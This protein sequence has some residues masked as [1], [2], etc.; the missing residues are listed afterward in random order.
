MGPQLQTDT[1]SQVRDDIELPGYDREAIK[2]GIVHFGP[3][4]FHRAHQAVFTDD[5][6]TKSG[7]DWGICG[8]SLNSRGTAE[9]MTAQHGLYTLAIKDKTPRY[10]VIGAMKEALC[11]RDDPAR[12]LERLSAASTKFVTMTITE[13][14]YALTA[15][16]HLDKMNP[17]IQQDLLNPE[18][19]VSAI[20]YLVLAI[21]DRKNKDLLPLT[22]ISCDNL[23]D[24]GHK[25]A[26]VC[27][28]YAQDLD[29]E[30]AD[31][32]KANVRFPNTMVDSI[33]PATDEA[34]KNTVAE[35]TGLIDA[36]P[37]Q[38]EA[39]KQWVIEDN[40]PEDRPD[41]AGAGA[42]ITSDVAGFEKTKLR[43]LNGAHSTLT[44]LG[45]LAGLESVE[46]A[47]N[48]PH[49]R[50]F[51]DTM[52]VHETIPTIE[53]PK[54]LS[55]KH[56]W[57]QIIARFEN[58]HIRHLLEQISHDG[59]QKIPARI[60]PVI[61]AHIRQGHLAK[62]ACFVLSAWIVFNQTRRARNNPPTDGFLNTI[63][64][65]LPVCD[66]SAA[67]Y[68]AAFLALD[69]VIAPELSNNPDVKACVIQFC[70]TIS[71]LGVIAALSQL[72]IQAT[73]L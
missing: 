53:A 30:L 22:I 62:R 12:V 31:Y 69:T 24:N 18:T 68:A 66:L 4:A 46:D 9:A 25:L 16:G 45:L 47:I 28:E 10:R 44:Y 37:V 41:W 73:N 57:S 32:I 71:E 40:L 65:S 33:T 52:I 1:L 6:L 63:S 8:V 72:N 58:P 50:R 55:L 13:K 36:V 60:L 19:P 67:D 35:E 3:G 17:A 7:G 14:G 26:T 42:I 51:V 20:G 2:I 61:M 34:V 59:S 5:A 48:E 64:D 11:A 29:A 23:P 56:Y 54:G 49:L 39:F 15:D 21:R 70:K 27:I 43:I 38:R